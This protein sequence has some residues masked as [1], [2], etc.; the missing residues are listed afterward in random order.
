MCTS[1]P[2]LLVLLVW[3]GYRSLSSFYIS[4]PSPFI[5]MYVYILLLHI[6]R[7]KSVSVVKFAS[8]VKHNLENWRGEENGF[9]SIFYLFILVVL[10]SQ[11]FKGLLSFHFCQRMSFSHS[12]KV[13]Q[14][15][16]N[17]LLFSS[18]VNVLTFLHSWRM[19]SLDI[20]FWLPFSK[21]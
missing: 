1:F 11:Y 9:S 3:V 13:G 10:L 20:E 21:F 14:L 18:S 2:R 12:F 7:I 16:T 6:L 19:F 5:I 15:A 17:Y 4:L 8:I